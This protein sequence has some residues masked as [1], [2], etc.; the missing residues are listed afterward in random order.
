[1]TFDIAKLKS[2]SAGSLSKI[3]KKDAKNRFEDTRF[4]KLER[5]KKTGNGQAIIRF[6][7][8]LTEDGYPWEEVWTYFVKAPYG[9]YAETSLRTIGQQD[10]MAEYISER[11]K[12]AATEADKKVLRDSGMSKPQHQYIANILV[13]NDPAHPE[14][15]GQVKLFKFGQK[16]YDK[17][18]DA[19]QP[20]FE[21]EQPI[22]VTD[23][24]AGANFYLNAHQQENGFPSYDRSKFSACTP[25]GDEQ[26]IVAIANKMYDL[27]E[28]VDPSKMKSYEELKAKVDRVTGRSAQSQ[29][30][31]APVQPQTQFGAPT[32]QFGVNQ[33]Y[34]TPGMQAPVFA[35]AAAPVAAVAA[36]TVAAKADEPAPWDMDFN[37]LMADIS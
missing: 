7:P 10:P 6:L 5:D 1:M 24:D 8:P 20:M 16:I 15:N 25:I 32:N 27:K 26:T 34:Q 22:N 19:S 28:F 18:V 12:A 2:I 11:W 21:G 35:E 9:V 23:W 36:A 37:Q 33:P 3:T 13:I 17:I 30:A 4:W 14:N 31:A 29:V